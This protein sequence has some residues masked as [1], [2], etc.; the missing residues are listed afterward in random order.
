MQESAVCMFLSLGG[1]VS[2]VSQL[3][4]F[5]FRGSLYM[6]FHGFIEPCIVCLFGYV[7]D[8]VMSE[9]REP[10]GT[11]SVERFDSERLLLL[12][13]D[14]LKRS[15]AF[16]V[17]QLDARKVRG[18]MKLRWSRSLTRQVGALVEVAEAL[19]RIRGGSVENVDLASYLSDLE[20]RVPSGFA[21]RKL[22]RIARRYR[23]NGVRHARRRI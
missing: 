17:G 14:I 15:I 5:P 9:V 1:L 11:D 22:S 3:F 4:C 8:S 10:I 6:E 23:M 20:Q 12:A 16:S 18:E 2:V 19:N 13:A 21:N 7:G